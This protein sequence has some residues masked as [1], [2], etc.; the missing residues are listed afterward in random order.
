MEPSPS[1][2]RVLEE[3]LDLIWRDHLESS[4]INRWVQGEVTRLVGHLT[5]RIARLERLGVLQS[6]AHAALMERVQDLEER[7]DPTTPSTTRK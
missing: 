2:S 4:E 7:I 6:Q 1:S 5:D 3:R